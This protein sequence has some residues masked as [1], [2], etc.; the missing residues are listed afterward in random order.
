MRYLRALALAC[1]LAVSVV[2]AAWAQSSPQ[3]NQRIT[4]ATFNIRV[5]SDRSRSDAELREIAQLVA[6]FDIVA[7]QETRDPAVLERLARLLETNFGLD[8]QFSDSLPL[9]RGSR[10]L[11]A[12]VWRSDRIKAVSGMAVAADPG[13]RFSREPAWQL[14]RAVDQGGKPGFD[15]VLIDF[16]AIFGGKESLR[17][18]EAQLLPSVVAGVEAAVRALPGASGEGDFLLLG[19][20]N[21][22]CADHAFDGLRA[23]G[24][25]PV[26]PGL[27]TTIK[28]SPYDNIWYFP[29]RTREYANEWGMVKF[30]ETEFDGN[31][32]RASREVSDHRPLWAS[33]A[34]AGDD[35]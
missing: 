1:L 18:A 17:R 12:F 25:V 15:F 22:S 31:D 33:F 21:L 30:D 34:S 32:E 3:P 2:G 23:M 7:I 28:D 24:M 26:C 16:H 6:G 14:F 20:F 19:D 4:V 10:E 11:Y 27:G 13:D 9:G 29:S 35:D 5:F 8:Y